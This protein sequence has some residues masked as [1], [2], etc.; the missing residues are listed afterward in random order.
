MKKSILFLVI[1]LVAFISKINASHIVGGE[2]QL[3]YSGKAYFYTINMNMYFDDINAQAGLIDGDLTIT[4]G[5]FSKATNDRIKTVDIKRLSDNLI[6]YSTNGCNNSSLLRTRLLN[7][8]GSIDLTGLTE[9]QGYYIAWER[10]CRNYQTQNIVHQ[11]ANGDY[12]SGQVFYLEFPPVA[13]LGVRFI[14]SSPIF[15]PIPAQY[16]CRSNFTNIDFSASDSDG[17]S[18]VYSMV[19]PLQGHATDLNSEPVPPYSAPY[20]LITFEPGYSTNNAIHGNPPLAINLHTGLLTVDPS[21]TGLFA[22]AIVCEEYRNGVK[23]GE[24]RRD[25]QFLIINCPVTHPPSVGLNASNNGNSNPGSTNWG[26][27][28]PDTLIVKLNRDTCYTIFVTDSSASFYH[29]SEPINIFYGSTNLPKS[30]LSF[31]PTQVTVTP[32]A[33][34]ATMNMCFSACD[35]VLILSDA[36]YYVDIVVQT[37]TCPKKSDTLRTYVHV[38]VESNN[39]PPKLSTSLLPTNKLTTYPDT[40]TTFYVYGTDPDLN[41]ISDITVNGNRF[42]LDEFRMHF[43]KVFTGPDSIAYHF[44]WIPNC[45]DLQKKTAYEIDFSLKDKSCIYTHTVNTHVNL[46]LQD[47]V[48][49]LKDLIPPNLVT[50]NDDNKNDCFYIP[51]LPPDNCTYKFKSIEIYNRWGSRIY[52]STSRDFKW[53]PKD[54]SDG[55]Y[56]YGIDLTA[57]YIKGW[58]E[59]LR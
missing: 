43:V 33:D 50:P 51:N 11:D 36:V 21:E 37:N 2:F 35:R 6:S 1:F 53:C 38:V 42:T 23:I 26:K 29:S 9:P 13:E 27:S 15:G 18:L 39:R 14:N 54:F 22:F 12:I 7:Y 25:F 47:A 19:N 56:Y 55:I 20:P 52:T 32:S 58:V 57:K 34:T 16:L 30:V 41:D 46:T 8:S 3:L 48:T 31:S 49:E 5:V 45:D 28:T 24:V 10:C 4:I 17:D 40:L 44:D 59:V